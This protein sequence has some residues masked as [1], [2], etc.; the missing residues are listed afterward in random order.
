MKDFQCLM[1]SLA[2]SGEHLNLRLRHFSDF[3]QIT[4]VKCDS[5]FFFMC[6]LTVFHMGR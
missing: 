2:A 4:P 6:S 1:V 3:D 5:Q